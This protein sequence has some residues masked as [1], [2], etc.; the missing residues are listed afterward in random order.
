MG[1]EDGEKQPKSAPPVRSGRMTLDRAVEMGE[2]DPDFLATFPEWYELSKHMQWHM[3]RKALENRR[4]FLV[5][6]W[7]ELANQPDYS[8]KPHLKQAQKGVER[9]LDEL[10]IDEE[11][12]Q[13]EFLA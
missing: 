4:R 12:L 10:Q 8:Q 7:S 11:R 5:V 3:I 1:F 13:V 9:Q 6:Q 2:Y